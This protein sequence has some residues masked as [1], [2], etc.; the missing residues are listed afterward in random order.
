MTLLSREQM[1]ELARV[2]LKT[3]DVPIP[4]SDLCVRIR[5]MTAAEKDEFDDSNVTFVNEKRTVSLKRLRAKMLAICVDE[6]KFTAEEW[7]DFPSAVVQVI[8]NAAQK[9]NEMSPAVVDAAEKNSESAPS[10]S[11]ASA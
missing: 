4:G 1:Q 9:L 5:V 8:F 2:E 11:S 7:G 10:A 6:P 3:E